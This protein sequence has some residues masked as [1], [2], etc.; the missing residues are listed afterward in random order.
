[1]LML[2]RTSK[3]TVVD[4]DVLVA[5]IKK[6][7]TEFTATHRGTPAIAIEEIEFGQHLFE[8]QVS[9]VATAD[10]LFG[11]HGADLTNLMFMRRGSGCFGAESALLV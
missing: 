11:I 5:F 9:A 8:E 2:K 10:I 4:W 6:L 3:R 7:A 1:M